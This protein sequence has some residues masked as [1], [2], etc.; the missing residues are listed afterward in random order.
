MLSQRLLRRLLDEVEDYA[1]PVVRDA[2]K[3][4]A[5]WIEQVVD[6]EKRGRIHVAA[7]WAIYLHDGRPAQTKT[8]GFFVYFR[9]RTQDPRLFGGRH[10][11]QTP[12][13]EKRLSR[14]DYERGL[15]LNA[16]A[17]AAGQEPPMLV[18]R[19]VGRQ[20]PNPF[21]TEGMDGVDGPAERAMLDEMEQ[22]ARE[23]VQ[24]LGGQETIDV[25]L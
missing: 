20:D 17:K 11:A 19:A 4:L 22:V 15:A 7:Y 6:S 8:N 1:R 21:F 3:T 10:L 23:L 9:D 13:Q 12:S 5:N 16:A 2:S 25:S 18:R 14:R 24:E